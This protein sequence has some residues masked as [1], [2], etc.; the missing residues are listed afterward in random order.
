MSLLPRP[1]STPSTAVAE[2]QANRARRWNRSAPLLALWTSGLRGYA[3]RRRLTSLKWLASSTSPPT[4]AASQRDASG[5]GVAASSAAAWE[6][7]RRFAARAMLR[8]CRALAR[9]ALVAPRRLTRAEARSRI[10]WV[11][12]AELV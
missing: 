6:P 8:S 5:M 7:A 11:A 2:P 9:S 12:R 10:A 1:L 4:E 3:D